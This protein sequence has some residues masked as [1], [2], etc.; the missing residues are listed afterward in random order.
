MDVP[1]DAPG[2]KRGPGTGNLDPVVDLTI[3]LSNSRNHQ[4]RLEL[5]CRRL[6]KSSFW[7][8][9]ILS[10]FLRKTQHNH[11]N[12]KRLQFFQYF[13]R[14][15][16]QKQADLTVSRPKPTLWNPY[17]RA[18]LAGRNKHFSYGSRIRHSILDKHNQFSADSAPSLQ[19]RSRLSR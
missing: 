13:L 10:P 14:Q 3:P 2:L 9:A 5:R 17:L 18:L 16:N 11:V 7:V 19:S 12:C 15:L 4:T 1:L 8:V 6:Q